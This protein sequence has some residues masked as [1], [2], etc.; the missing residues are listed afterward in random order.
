MAKK[1]ALTGSGFSVEQAKSIAGTG[2]QGLTA[3]GTN[4]ATALP[5]DSHHNAFTTVAA[6]TGAVLSSTLTPGDDVY[7]Y[8]G[9]AQTLT[10]YPAGA[11]DTID[12]GASATIVTL[13]GIWLKCCATVSGVTAWTSHKST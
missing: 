7:V 12:N 6:S 13:K 8:N 2:A 1:T 5:I 3:T 9:G 11:I 10:I 4:Q